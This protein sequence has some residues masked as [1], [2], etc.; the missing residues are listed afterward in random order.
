MLGRAKPAERNAVREPLHVPRRDLRRPAGRPRG[1]G[2][3]W[4]DC[5]FEGENLGTINNTILSPSHSFTNVMPGSTT[6]DVARYFSAERAEAFGPGRSL[7][8]GIV[9]DPSFGCTLGGGQSYATNIESVVADP[10]HVFPLCE[11]Y[12]PA[13]D[14]VLDFA[15]TLLQTEYSLTLKDDEHVTSVVIIG[16]DG[17]ERTL[18]MG[19]YTFDEA[20]GLLSFGPSVLRGSDVDLRIEVT[21][22]CRPIVR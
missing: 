4:H 20:T 5:G 15:Q 1:A 10:K 11:S 18:D 6:A 7:L 12:A 8:E 2:E 21:S 19:S 17:T 16:K 3:G 14:G 9:L 22:D 13:L